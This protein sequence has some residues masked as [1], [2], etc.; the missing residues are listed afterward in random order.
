MQRC[1]KCGDRI[2]DIISR[3]QGWVERLGR[4]IDS[5]TRSCNWQSEGRDSS[6]G[7]S[8]SREPKTL[9]FESKVP[10]IPSG[11]Y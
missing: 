8:S 7:A 11:N 5:W 10:V 4:L 6:R 2:L 1:G 9:D 3:S